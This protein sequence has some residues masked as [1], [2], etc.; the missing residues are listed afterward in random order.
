M[1]SPRKLVDL[2]IQERR[3]L[4]RCDFN[5]PLSSDGQ[6]R[7]DTRLQ[8]ALPTLRY[9][10]KQGAALTLM[11][12]LGRPKGPDAQYSLRCVAGRLQELLNQEVYF[13]NHCVGE[14][15][16]KKSQSLAPG[17]V[18]LLEN[19][20]FH[21][22]ETSASAPFAEQLAEHG[23]IYV[24]DAFGTAH[25]SHASTTTILQFF[26]EKGIGLL[27]EQELRALD[28]VLNHP[29]KPVVG[30]VGGAKISDKIGLLSHLINRL[31]V[32][33]VGGGMSHTFTAALGGEVG[34]SLFEPSAIS[35]ARS[36]YKQAAPKQLL[37]PTDVC[38]AESLSA[39][40]K[41]RICDA[42]SIPKGWKG[43]D[44]GPETIE[45]FAEE[46][47][48]AETIIWN[49]PMGVAEL[50]P[51]SKGTEAIAEAIKKASEARASFSLA[52]GG[53]SV[54]IIKRLGFEAYVS[55]LSTGGGALLTAL[56]GKGLPALTSMA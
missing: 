28:R 21:P 39:N 3:V 45:R 24:N 27:I 37:L 54:S 41:T 25:R 38:I 9:V 46:I 5:V 51:F 36:L 6:I 19:L 40:S 48:Q 29:Q 11:S 55:H 35:I 16:R 10:L 43:L 8:E 14:E 53:D 34:D 42:R 47:A 15:A 33:L 44:I 7:D 22:G 20:R 1:K 13:T 18:L 56:E 30:I 17:E 23:E 31:D 26:K 2:K 50:L 32:L 12:H 49:G 4:L 52:G